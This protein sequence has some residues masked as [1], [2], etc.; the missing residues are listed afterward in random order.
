M[1]S[2]GAMRGSKTTPEGRRMERKH[3]LGLGGK[4]KVSASKESK[5]KK[6]SFAESLN[7]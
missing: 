1:N 4:D 7:D 6:K 5:K 3:E 2:I